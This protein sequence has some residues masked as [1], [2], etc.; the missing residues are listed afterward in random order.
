MSAQLL[1]SMDSAQINCDVHKALCPILRQYGL[2]A[3]VV[4]I[5]NYTMANEGLLECIDRNDVTGYEYH[6]DG[7]NLA[8]ITAHLGHWKDRIDFNYTSE[9]LGHSG[10]TALTL[11][12]YRSNCSEQVVQLLCDN[13]ANPNEKGSA[14]GYPGTHCILQLRS[15]LDGSNTGVIDLQQKKLAILKAAAKKNGQKL[16]LNENRGLDSL[17]NDDDTKE[18]FVDTEVHKKDE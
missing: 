6:P 4:S 16:F 5:K 15:A 11:A 8:S 10:F 18:L 13:G 2:D 9:V 14:A 7:R 12:C 3:V 1:Y 17:R